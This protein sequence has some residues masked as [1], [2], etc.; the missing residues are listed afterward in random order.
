MNNSSCENETKIWYHVMKRGGHDGH[1]QSFW[2]IFV[3]INSNVIC[4]KSLITVNNLT[5]NGDFLVVIILKVHVDSH[6]I[7]FIDSSK[8]NKKINNRNSSKSE[9]KWKHNISALILKDY[10]SPW[11]LIKSN[12]HSVH[13]K[14]VF[15]SPCCWFYFVS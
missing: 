2:I 14:N 12:P 8:K 10:F 1:F 9:E 4:S 7:D 3:S 11:I 5:L 15:F 6:I 13:Y